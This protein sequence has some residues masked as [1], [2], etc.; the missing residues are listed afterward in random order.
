M[1]RLYWLSNFFWVGLLACESPQG[2]S[3]LPVLGPMELT[4]NTSGGYDTTYFD[5]PDYQWID[6]D[7]LPF[8]PDSLAGQVF[9][10]DFFFTSCPTICID[11]RS[12]L[13]RVYKQF[14]ENQDFRIVSHTIDS[15]YD[16]PSVLK[17]YAEYCGVANRN[18]L[19]VNG[20]E[21]EVYQVAKQA[22]LSLASRDSTAAGGFLHSG[23]FILLDKQKR[24]RGVYDGTSAPE[25]DRLIEE[26]PL[27]LQE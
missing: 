25:V 7:S 22:Y 11:M 24:I 23:T 4:A 27:L 8:T 5:Y 15:E 19:F 6:Q 14:G 1:R 16:R 3:Q 12:E 18:W 2:D 26:L 9:L 13:M 10:V 20:P 21:S 17:N